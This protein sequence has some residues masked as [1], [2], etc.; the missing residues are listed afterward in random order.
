MI[1][2]SLISSRL[3]RFGLHGDEAHRAR[4]VRLRDALPGS[5]MINRMRCSSRLDL[6][7]AGAEEIFLVA[8]VVDL[9]E[10]RS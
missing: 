10:W 3:R 4:A 5:W 9:A 1:D 6:A 7:V 2:E 8:S